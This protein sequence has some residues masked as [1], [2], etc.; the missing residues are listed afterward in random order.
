MDIKLLNYLHLIIILRVKYVLVP[1][2]W[3]KIGIRP[4]S[5]L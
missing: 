5:K 4:W 1:E 2:L 3:S